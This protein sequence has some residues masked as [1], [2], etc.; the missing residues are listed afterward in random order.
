MQRPAITRFRFIGP[1]FYGKLN[2][3]TVMLSVFYFSGFNTARCII[4]P[5]V[6]A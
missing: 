5:S 2:G 3:M 6:F 4:N 1:M